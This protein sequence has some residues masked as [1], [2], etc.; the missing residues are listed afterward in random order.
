MVGFNEENIYN[1][2]INEYYVFIELDED[3][4]IRMYYFYV[5]FLK[6]MNIGLIGVVRFSVNR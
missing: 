5:I 1:W 2:F 6:D 3:C 4:V